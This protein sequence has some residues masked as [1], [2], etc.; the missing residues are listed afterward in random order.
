M[1][2]YWYARAIR[3]SR[4]AITAANFVNFLPEPVKYKFKIE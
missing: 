3:K 2:R 1:A 4:E